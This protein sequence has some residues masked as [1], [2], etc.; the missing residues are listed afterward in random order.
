MLNKN[1]CG[2]ILLKQIQE[3]QP[4][5][6]T[7][8]IFCAFDNS[9]CIISFNS[10]AYSSLSLNPQMCKYSSFSNDMFVLEY[11]Q[12][13]QHLCI[14]SNDCWPLVYKVTRRYLNYTQLNRLLLKKHEAIS[15]TKVHNQAKYYYALVLLNRNKYC[16]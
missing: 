16:R 14:V 13:F 9:F 15:Y 6:R 4:F 2:N 5:Y 8:N 1:I 12:V 3:N 11:L 10:S 7:N